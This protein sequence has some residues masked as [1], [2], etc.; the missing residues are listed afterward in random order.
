MFNEILFFKGFYKVGALFKFV[1]I[2]PRITELQLNMSHLLHWKGLYHS[3]SSEWQKNM[4]S[5]IS[6][7]LL[8]QYLLIGWC[9]QMQS[10]YIQ[11]KKSTISLFQ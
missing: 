6:E 11:K 3:L 8:K 10:Y 5:N 1:C 7:V 9:I 4:T 2:D